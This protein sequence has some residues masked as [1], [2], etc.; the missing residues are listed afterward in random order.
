MR[1]QSKKW[2]VLPAAAAVAVLAGCAAPYG[3]GHSN[4]GYNTAPPPG[5]QTP[6]STQAPAGSVYYGRVESIEPITSTQGSSGL[7]GTVIGGAAGGLLGHQVGGGRGQTAATIGG[8]VV[9]AV[10]GNQIEKRAGSNTQNAYRVNVR[11]DD[12]RVATVTQ[13]SLGN[14]Q[15]GMRAR[16]ANDMATAY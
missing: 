16:V 13:S 4:T 3:G 12:G 2:L 5:Y 14:L 1:M 9:G 10:A 7:L 6:N 15:V 11:L 8:A